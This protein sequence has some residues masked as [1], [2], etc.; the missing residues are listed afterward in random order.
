MA[1]GNMTNVFFNVLAFLFLLL[2]VTGLFLLIQ[3][4]FVLKD[5]LLSQRNHN[6]LL[7]SPLLIAWGLVRLAAGRRR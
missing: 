2:G 1:R 4:L 5:F 7:I 3:H 6:M